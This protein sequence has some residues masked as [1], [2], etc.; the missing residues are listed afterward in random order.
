[1]IL[2]SYK[3]YQLP[4]ITRDWEVWPVSGRGDIHVEAKW[5]LLVYCGAS[6]MLV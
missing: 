4:E 2:K 5:G 3:G 6:N 1:M